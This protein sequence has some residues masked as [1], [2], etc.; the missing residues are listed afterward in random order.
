MES[1]SLCW[2]IPETG[3]RYDHLHMVVDE[4]TQV[5]GR[6]TIRQAVDFEGQSTWFYYE[7]ALYDYDPVHQGAPDFNF[8][9]FSVQ[10]KECLEVDNGF[11]DYYLAVRQN[12]TV[13]SYINPIAGGAYVVDSNYQ[14]F[15]LSGQT[16][17]F[18]PSSFEQ[19][20]LNLSDPALKSYSYNTSNHPN[21]TST[22]SIIR[23]GILV[24]FSNPPSSTKLIETHINDFAVDCSRQPE[25]TKRIRQ[26]GVVSTIASLTYGTGN[27]V[28]PREEL[29]SFDRVALPKDQLISGISRNIPSIGQEIYPDEF[30]EGMTCLSPVGCLLTVQALQ[31]A[32][33]NF[34][35]WI[36]G[37]CA[38]S[39][40]PACSFNCGV[41]Q[42]LIAQ[43]T[44]SEVCIDNY[45]YPSVTTTLSYETENTALEALGL[46]WELSGDVSYQITTSGFAGNG[47]QISFQ[48]VTGIHAAF[49]EQAS[50]SFEPTVQ[51]T[52]E[53]FRYWQRIRAR[54]E[55]YTPGSGDILGFYA[56]RQGSKVYR[57]DE[58]FV[59]NLG[60]VNSFT[61]YS[62]ESKFNVPPSA[63]LSFNEENFIEVCADI[64]APAYLEN[65]NSQPNFTTGDRITF[66]FLFVHQ[67]SSIQTNT[68]LV[69]EFLQNY[70]G[71]SYGYRPFKNSVVYAL[72]DLGIPAFNFINP[73]VAA[74]A[75]KPGILP[76]NPLAPVEHLALYRSGRCIS[77]EAGNNFIQWTGGPCSGSTDP[78]CSFKIT[79][80]ELELRAIFGSQEPDFPTN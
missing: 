48:N 30:T 66:G 39:T 42:N 14:T 33:Y 54:S 4:D 78:L 18:I 64:S 75:I 29:F 72:A 55:S 70:G 15:T 73:N 3:Y 6:R 53:W 22:G 63:N 58:P 24:H 31:P 71:F 13:Y 23:F 1:R 36:S 67:T 35:E 2:F 46:C 79:S 43:F 19:R 56:L 40:N 65:N 9:D 57:L 50:F 47:L 21:F 7:A 76:G 28:A 8:Y 12:D 44:S 77:V 11:V 17:T 25:V 68:I 32:G 62:S 10:I 74:N 26:L 52:F 5:Q 59:A 60:A 51:G 38:G 45:D 27:F 34:V 37:P 20:V 16:E 61:E 41:E 49:I 80:T 69:D